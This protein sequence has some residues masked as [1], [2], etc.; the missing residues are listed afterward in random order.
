[1]EN[2]S[3]S[4]YQASNGSRR[5]D[6]VLMFSFISH[7]VHIQNLFGWA[8]ALQKL[9]NASTR[10]KRHGYLYMVVSFS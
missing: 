1:M 2:F 10:T 6:D 4:S 3:L 5:E 8:F 9:L 7:I